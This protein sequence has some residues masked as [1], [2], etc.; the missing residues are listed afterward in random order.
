VKRRQRDRRNRTAATARPGRRNGGQAGSPPRAAAS[1]HT[2][3]EARPDGQPEPGVVHARLVVNPA[4]FGFAERLD[5]EGSIFVPPQ[6]RGGAMDGDEVVVAFWPA[7]RGVEGAVRSVVKRERN[8]V[9]GLLRRAGKRHFVEP[10]DPRVLG[11]AEVVGDPPPDAVGQIVVAG[12][13]DYPDPWDDDFTVTVERTLGAPNTLATEEAKILLE[14]GID[15]LMP[16]A[17]LEA[18]KSVPD[19]VRRSDIEGRADLRDYEF[20]TIDP[21]DARDFDDAV[22]VE[23]LG[24]DPKRAKMRVHVAVADVSHYVREGDVFDEEAV[25]RCFSTYLPDRAIPM[26]PEALSSDICSLVPKKDRLAMVV[27]MT[28]DPAGK[29]SEI[30]VCAAVIRSRA[31]L[32]YDQA[33]QVLAGRGKLPPP[34]ADR[35]RTL[36]A[37]ADRLARMRKRRGSIGLD[38]PEIRIKLDQDDPERVREIVAARADPSVARAYNLIEE[39]MLAANEAVAHLAGEHRLPV[40][41]RIHDVP[42]EER[43]ERLCAVAELMAVEIEP[44]E[45]RTPSGFSKLV[46]KLE[47]HPRR[48]ALHGQLLRTLAQA[49]YSTQNVGHFALAAPAYLH[50]TSPIRRYPDLVCHRV[51]KAWLARGGGKAGPSPVPRMPALATTRAQAEQASLRERAAIAAERDAKALFAAHYMRDR[52]GDRVEGTVGGIAS[53]GVFVTLDDPPVDGM[54]RRGLIERDHREKWMMDDLGARLL[55]ASSGRT[56]TIGDRVIVEVIDASPARRQIDLAL[57]T[58]LSTS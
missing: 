26:L 2:G 46:A 1:E 49:E 53:S 42:E 16:P 29:T 57:I 8:R 48:L 37:A 58:L 43:V 9:T 52:I 27:S 15:P 51:M 39:L 20:M 32:T 19:R 47:R 41:Y 45:L 3:A 22:C 24:K 17:V 21:P 35:I 50:F 13:V 11:R 4:G 54:V 14:H 36:R 10:D 28:L 40:M 33:A 6:K 44:E 34:I 30:E 56:I 7:E 5:G 55:G 12:I 18:A 25:R 38:L 23:V 31:R